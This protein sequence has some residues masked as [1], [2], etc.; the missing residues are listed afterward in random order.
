MSFMIS[1]AGLEEGIADLNAAD[2][3]AMLQILGEEDQ[4]EEAGLS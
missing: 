1:A 2:G 3:A 4:R